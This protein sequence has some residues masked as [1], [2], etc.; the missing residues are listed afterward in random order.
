MK[1]IGNRILK[2]MMVMSMGILPATNIECEDGEFE[3]HSDHDEVCYDCCHGCDGWF[4]FGDY[5][6]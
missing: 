5:W 1:R 3:F 2:A 6:W 4:Y